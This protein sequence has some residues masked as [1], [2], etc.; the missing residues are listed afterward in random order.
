ML[1]HG[2]SENTNCGQHIYGEIVMKNS[3]IRSS[4]C[5][6]FMGTVPLVA[7]GPILNVSSSFICM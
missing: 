5:L 4:G 1:W 6:L 3:S 2:E 7:G